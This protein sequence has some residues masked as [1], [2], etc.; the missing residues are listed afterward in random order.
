MKY[1]NNTNSY[2][3]LS[4]AYYDSLESTNFMAIR[5][6]ED[7]G[8]AKKIYFRIIWLKVRIRGRVRRTRSVNLSNYSTE[9]ANPKTSLKDEWCKCKAFELLNQNCENPSLPHCHAFF[10]VFLCSGLF[11]SLLYIYVLFRSYIYIIIE[12]KKYSIHHG[13]VAMVAMVFSKVLLF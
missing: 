7:R 6:G 10:D 1:R 9:S 3:R 11:L 8:G 13:N 5:K 4:S 2:G 12:I